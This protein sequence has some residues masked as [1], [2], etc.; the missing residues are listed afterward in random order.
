[1]QDQVAQLTGYRFLQGYGSDEE[2]YKALMNNGLSYAKQYN[3]RPGIA[4]TPEQ[5]AQ[6]S[7]DIV[8]LVEKETT[9]PDGTKTKAL[10]PQVYV[11]ARVGDLKGDGTLI[12]ADSIQLNLSK[13]LTNAG[14]IAGRQVVQ[15]NS[16]NLN[17]LA[18]NIRGGV[19]SISTEKDLN[20][21]GGMI[22]ADQAM[23]LQV[24][25]NLNIQS[26]TQSSQNALGQ[27]NYSWTGIDRIAGLYI[28]SA[29][30]QALSD[31]PTLVMNVGGD[32][33]ILAAN[34]QNNS[35]GRSII[36]TGGDLKVGSLNT[37]VTNNVVGSSKAYHL[38]TRQVEVGSQI[39]SQ[40]DLSLQGNNIQIHGSQISSSEGLTALQAKERLQI[41]EGRNK[42]D[43]QDQSSFSKKGKLS[44]STTS[45]FSHRSSDIAVGSIV[46][47]KKVLLDA[48]NINVR[49]SN[50]VSDE[51]TQIQAKDNANIEGAQNQY[52][53]QTNSVVKNSGLMSTGGIGFSLGKKQET[54][55]KTEQQLTNSASQVGSL[56]GNTNIVAGKTYQQTGSTVSS[57]KG[58]VNILAQQINIEAAKEQSTSDY[59]HEMQ[60]KGLTL[61]VN[62]PVVSAVQSVAE[63]AKQVGQSKN[64]RVNAMAAANAGFDAY[65]AGQALSSLQGALSNAGSLNGGVEVGVSLT[66]G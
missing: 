42:L 29:Q 28:G 51:L 27:S 49:G 20:N 16:Q 6:L 64:D 55:L 36:R 12:S 8:W 21:I 14:T 4:L 18:G 38:D 53:S 30:Q 17:N 48:G 59:K 46:E 61:A 32:T 3:L 47:G 35:G 1:V 43:Q 37:E 57:Q 63:S 25:G 19:V 26:T 50:I 56:N 34:I 62:V 11:K 22:Q 31:Q 45:D 66:Y 10:V 13:D 54:T 52:N 23:N 60:Q 5:M 15:I 33:R 58:D 24:K 44:S 2:Q 7:S 39:K 65:K 41:E 9:L 40:G